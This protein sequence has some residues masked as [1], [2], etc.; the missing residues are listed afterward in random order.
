MRSSGGRL[1]RRRRTK[2]DER[3]AG[4]GGGRAEAFG[5]SDRLVMALGA[6]R[7]AGV[8]AGGSGNAGFMTIPSGPDTHA[9]ERRRNAPRTKHRVRGSREAAAAGSQ[10]CASAAQGH[11][12]RAHGTH[13]ERVCYSSNGNNR[14][15]AHVTEPVFCPA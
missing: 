2:Q 10:G 7:S 5:S 14:A 11:A 1:R 3:M 9:T 6:L 8:R 13:N 12:V 15:R 4:R